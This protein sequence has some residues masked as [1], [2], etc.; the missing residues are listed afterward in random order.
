MGPG[1]ADVAQ[2]GEVRHWNA[3]VA[4]VVWVL[5]RDGLGPLTGFT[6]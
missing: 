2:G 6:I 3:Y 1:Q 4:G 5:E